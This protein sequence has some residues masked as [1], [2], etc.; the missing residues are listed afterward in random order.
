MTQSIRHIRYPFWINGLSGRTAE[1]G[2]YS[3]YIRQLIRQVLLTAKGERVCR[4]QFGAGVRRQV[5]APLS[6]ETAALTKTIVFEALNRWLGRFIRV[7]KIEV[8]ADM[9]TLTISIEYLLIARGETRI[10][11]EE[12]PL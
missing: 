7:D 3:Q 6:N 12:V 5:F 4:P 8:F 10:L 2:D 9:A 1:E 11:N